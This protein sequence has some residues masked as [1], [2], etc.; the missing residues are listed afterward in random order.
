MK[1]T[2]TKGLLLPYTV[3]KNYDKDVHAIGGREGY[4]IIATRVGVEISN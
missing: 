4:H 3:E 2:L 1:G